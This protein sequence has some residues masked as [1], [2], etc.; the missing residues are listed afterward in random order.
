M[1]KRLCALLLGLLFVTTHVVTAYAEND[2]KTAN[3][4]DIYRQNVPEP[5]VT[6]GTNEKALENVDDID[7]DIKEDV[8]SAI[9]EEME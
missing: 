5:S 6:T 1:K 3:E 2:E 9:P 8:E 7:E 4:E